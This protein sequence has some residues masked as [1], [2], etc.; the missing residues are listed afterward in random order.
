MAHT[1]AEVGCSEGGYVMSSRSH[2]GYGVF[3]GLVVAVGLCQAKGRDEEVREVEEEIKNDVAERGGR[4]VDARDLQHAADFGSK[5]VTH[6]IVSH[7]EQD[8]ARLA[9]RSGTGAKVVTEWWV[10]RCIESNELVAEDSEVTFEPPRSKD[11]ISDEMKDMLVCVTGY[12]G[13]RRHAMRELVGR[14]GARYSGTLNKNCTHLIC[15]K[16]EGEKYKTARKWQ[17]ACGTPSIVNHRWVEDCI[18]AWTYISEPVYEDKCG[19]EADRDAPIPLHELVRLEVE[20]SVSQEED[21]EAE[22]EP[23][24]GRYAAGRASRGGVPGAGEADP[25]AVIPVATLGN[26]EAEREGLMEAAEEEEVL[27]AEEEEEEEEDVSCGQEGPSAEARELAQEV[28]G[29][30]EKQQQESDGNAYAGDTGVSG[31]RASRELRG[32]Q[33]FSWDSQRRKFPPGEKLSNRVQNLARK[34]VQ[35]ER[36]EAGDLLVPSKKRKSSDGQKAK[37]EKKP[38]IKAAKTVP[39]AKRPAQQKKKAKNP[40]P[41]EPRHHD[42]HVSLSGM[43]SKVRLR[44]L[45]YA[46]KCGVQIA[47]FK[48]KEWRE[49]TT[50][51]VTPKLGRSEKTLA[52]MASGAW[53]VK[54]GWL[55]D[56]AKV[57]SG[58]KDE[59]D[60]FAEGSQDD[61]VTRNAG[62]IWA[63]HYQETKEKAFEGLKAFFHGGCAQN[64]PSTDTLIRIFKA[65]NG[66]VACS[67]EGVDFAVVPNLEDESDP[68]VREC[69]ANNIALVSEIFIIEYLALPTKDLASL[70]SSGATLTARMKTLIRSRT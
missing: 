11:G 66:Q 8:L 48:S 6:V 69:K 60:Y 7:L 57:K 32:L 25:A 39:S 34:R 31:G 37:E 38:K 56:C 5:G 59:K 65:G 54:E 30:E 49:G 28:A 16:Y 52:G 35:P 19:E 47:E 70:V 21:S 67:T 9:K 61:L 4:V 24:S 40:A 20:N 46:D 12:S 44:C 23:R 68:V 58:L 50:H 1:T 22:D 10:D 51:V 55:R 27:A 33:L 26:D 13:I 42:V 53:I 14:T 41:V 36:L 29:D 45:K 2:G 15:Y 64:A 3:D 62:E 43:R 18:R 63:R 17:S